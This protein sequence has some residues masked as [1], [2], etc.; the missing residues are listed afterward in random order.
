MTN[1]PQSF[2]KIFGGPGTGKTTALLRSLST[3]LTQDAEG[4]GPSFCILT[5]SRVQSHDL[6]QKMI[7]LG[8]PSTVL[9]SVGTFHSIGSRLICFSKGQ[10]LTAHEMRTY[11]LKTWKMDVR[12]TEKKE[13]L[14]N[15]VSEDYFLRQ[16]KDTSN[17][18]EFLLTV[19]DRCRQEYVCPFLHISKKDAYALWSRHYEEWN[20]RTG[21][22]LDFSR[23][24]TILR[25]YEMWKERQDKMDYTDILLQVLAREVTQGADGG[26]S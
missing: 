23:H 13:A 19:Y 10:G 17:E 26:G 16:Q 24:W 1:T 5:F 15:P 3:H 25:E 6:Q 7:T 12:P 11:F 14:A 4:G 8:Y 2:I 21:G 20:V 18:G 22:V 9:R